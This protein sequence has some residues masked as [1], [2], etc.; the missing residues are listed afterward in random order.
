MSM[1]S[2]EVY[3][4][5]AFASRTPFVLLLDRR[6]TPLQREAVIAVLKEFKPGPYTRETF[7]C[8]DFASAFKGRVGHGIGIAI[9]P[10]HAWNIALCTDGV[11]HIEPQ[12]GAFRRR[13][14]A[15]LII[16]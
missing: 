4:R 14:T 15:V 8:D 5:V 16:L 2:I 12:T 7:D 6:Y 9:S 13:K 3:F 1:N 10:R 11:W